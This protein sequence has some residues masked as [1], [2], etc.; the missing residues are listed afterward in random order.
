MSDI[1][2][3]GSLVVNIV[4]VHVCLTR[5]LRRVVDYYCDTVGAAHLPV[6]LT[7]SQQP[8]RL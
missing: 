5:H 1:V 6:P 3:V 8:L 2:I 7:F 4:R